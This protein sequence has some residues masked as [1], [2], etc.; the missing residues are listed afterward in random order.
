MQTGCIYRRARASCPGAQGVYA[1]DVA[2]FPGQFVS[3]GDYDE[4]YEAAAE[5]ASLFAARV[6]PVLPL[7]HFSFVFLVGTLD[8]DSRAEVTLEPPR[9]SGE[10]DLVEG[11]WRLKIVTFRVS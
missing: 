9:G 2:G 4:E 10:D 1:P 11:D 3:F 5:S 8:T 6:L 7:S